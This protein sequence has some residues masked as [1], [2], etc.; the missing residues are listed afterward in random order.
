MTR[1]DSRL[2]VVSGCVAGQLENLGRQILHDR[3][4]VDG[5]T[6][7]DT[8]GVVALAQQTVNSTDGELK[9]STARSALRLSLDFA[10]FSSARHICRLACERKTKQKPRQSRNDGT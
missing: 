2:L 6:G 4:K 1:D 5:S 8:L 3:R 7:T 10:S 9:T